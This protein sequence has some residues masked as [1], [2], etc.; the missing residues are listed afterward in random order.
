MS[1]SACSIEATKIMSGIVD[2]SNQKLRHEAVECKTTSTQQQNLR[3]I[4]QAR[5]TAVS[6]ACNTLWWL[7]TTAVS[8]IGFGNFSSLAFCS[9]AALMNYLPETLP[10]RSSRSQKSKCSPVV[11]TKFLHSLN[12]VTG[13]CQELKNS[14]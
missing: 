2:F 6:S 10:R 4:L 1:V 11:L 14:V 3:Q 5:K 13:G 12:I 8:S 7:S 9:K